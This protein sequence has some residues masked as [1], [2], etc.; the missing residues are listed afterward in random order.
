MT[1]RATRPIPAGHLSRRSLLL[2]AAVV[3]F[4][5]VGGTEFGEFHT[6]VRAINAWIGAV[7]IGYWLWR[8]PNRADRTDLLIFGALIPFL[9]ACVA[10]DYLRQSYPA[11]TSAVAYAA[12]FSVTRWEVADARSARALITILALSG[13]VLSVVFLCLWGSAWAGWI[14]VTGSVPPLDLILPV[15]PYRGHHFVAMLFT[16]LL[17]ALIQVT[18]R[19]SASVIGYAGIAASLA[20]IYMAG[21]RTVWLALAAGVLL[22]L[23]ALSIRASRVMLGGL[24]ALV[25][26]A[27]GMAVTG[28]LSLVLNRLA[29]TSTIDL[30]L[31]IWS[32][33]LGLWLVDPIFGTGPGSFSAA[34]TFTDYFD[35]YERIG[36]HADSAF[37]QV[38]MEAGVLGLVTFGLLAAACISGMRQ[39]DGRW[40]RPALMGIAMFALMSLTN[41]PSEMA[42]L[43]VIGLCWAA[44]CTPAVAPPL[45]T[46]WSPSWR[47][48]AIGVA[49]L[50]V[51]V[52]TGSMLAASAAFDASQAAARSTDATA[53][54]RELNRA[55]SLDPGHSL[56]WRERGLLQAAA[57][58]SAATSDL[59]QALRLN[60]ADTT[61]MRA[62]AVLYARDGDDEA[63]MTLARRAASLR[64]TH[65]E[66][67]STLALVASMTGDD[68]T[69]TQALVELLRRMPW[70]S[71]SPQ[72]S[73]NFPA[74]EDLHD[75]FVAADDDWEDREEPSPRFAMP[76]VWLNAAIGD[77]ASTLPTPAWVESVVHLRAIDGLLRCEI[78]RAADAILEPPPRTPS[79]ADLIAMITTATIIGSADQIEEAVA[80]GALRPG[81]IG[82]LARIQPEPVS[83]FWD[84]SEDRRLYQRN[85][86]VPVDLGITLPTANEGLSAWLMDPQRA[87]RIGAPGSGLAVCAADG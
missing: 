33:S 47:T 46:A 30:R 10:S 72:W 14:S 12:A 60:P 42:N 81:G 1:V 50:V 28:A 21:S 17:P 41:N 6:W 53:N 78:E 84:P 35:R 8:L 63:A 83:P 9:V 70:I 40:T 55:I 38:L 19:R 87:A 3:W 73:A 48:A 43:V 4:V 61:A 24:L 31:E 66:N 62:L 22:P 52:A 71:A 59:R 58:E 11:A 34:F 76:Q 20:L 36:R 18:R 39:A 86:V 74:G 27:V 77:S 15:G 57:G 80:L 49:G 79:Q 25:G 7:I 32:N 23:A 67:L 26:L 64:P 16:L 45:W 75:L 85:A 37:V 13:I 29:T 54:I 51:A 5:L 56:Y 44:L 68:E 65:E 2:G 69:S 82:S